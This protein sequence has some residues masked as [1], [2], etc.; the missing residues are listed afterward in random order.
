MSST[1]YRFVAYPDPS[2]LGLYRPTAS[3]NPGLCF[4]SEQSGL[5]TPTDP[6]AIQALVELVSEVTQPMRLP[7][8]GTA[9]EVHLP[10]SR[11]QG[12]ALVSTVSVVGTCLELAPLE[13]DL[14]AAVEFV[15]AAVFAVGI[16]VAVAAGLGE[17][18][19]PNRFVMT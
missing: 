6:Q 15:G 14:S 4:L 13:V 8:P 5:V 18:G 7:V 12:M 16:A 11:S 19:G 17:I 1:G 10:L 2:F 3:S 9:Y